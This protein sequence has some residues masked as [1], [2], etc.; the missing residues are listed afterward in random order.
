MAVT[1]SSLYSEAL[2]NEMRVESA[3][4]RERAASFLVK[5]ALSGMRVIDPAAARRVGDD[6]NALA[7]LKQEFLDDLASGG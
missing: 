6:V 3:T 4:A 2:H 7:R 1:M 5:V